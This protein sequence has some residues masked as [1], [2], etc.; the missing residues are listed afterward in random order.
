M[1]RLIILLLIVGCED[2]GE[3]DYDFIGTW[4]YCCYQD[5]NGNIID[6][7]GT[8]SQS[9][10]FLFWTFNQDGTLYEHGFVAGEE[11]TREFIWIT[12]NN[13]LDSLLQT[14][15]DEQE[16]TELRCKVESYEIIE[17]SLKIEYCG[18]NLQIY[19]KQ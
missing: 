7:F 18:F 2:D 11:G 6:G 17:D 10:D 5:S 8:H 4:Q 13:S 14:K 16:N 15:S 9:N 1:K 12:K 3:P 19:L